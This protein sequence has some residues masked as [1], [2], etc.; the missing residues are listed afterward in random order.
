MLAGLHR[1]ARDRRDR[2]AP[3]TRTGAGPHTDGVTVAA[4]EPNDAVTDEPRDA[5][6]TIVR[7]IAAWAGATPSDPPPPSLERLYRDHAGFV[8]RVVRRLGIPDAVAEDVVQEIFIIA[9]RK[10]PEYSGRGSPRAWLHGI[11]RGVCSNTRRSHERHARRLSV[12]TSPAPPPDPGELLDQKLAVRAIETFLTTLSPEQRAVFELMEIEGMSGPEVA[13]A[14]EINLNVAY[15]R[16]RLARKRFL[17][18]LAARKDLA[19]DPGS[20]EAS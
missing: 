3:S 9:R 10:L 6:K 5:H 13:Q 1:P 14:L 15:S 20:Q 12:L 16:Q 17:Q 8:W 7:R 18:F 19:A 11:A 4:K 2:A